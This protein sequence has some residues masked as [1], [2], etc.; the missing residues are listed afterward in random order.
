MTSTCP[1]CGHDL[2]AL[3]MTNFGQLGIEDGGSRIYWQTHEVRLTRAERL[4][5][6][7]IV[8]LQGRI[9]SWE[10]LCEIA[11]GEA[12]ADPK[13]VVNVLVSRIRKLFRNVD[14]EFTCIETVWGV[15]LRWR[16][17]NR[18]E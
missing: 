15:G 17:D 18:G 5:V 16:A 11:P 1:H 7:G 2:A 10:A 8:R 3:E 9:I 12:C 6:L 13:N 14:P 4:I